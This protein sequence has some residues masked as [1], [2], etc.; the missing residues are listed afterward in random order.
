ML[1]R[2]LHHPGGHCDFLCVAFDRMAADMLVTALD[3][4][5]EASPEQILHE[6]FERVYYSGPINLLSTNLCCSM[7]HP[8]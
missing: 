4:Y 5:G 1:A 3:K 7:H 8:Y 6:R 2:V